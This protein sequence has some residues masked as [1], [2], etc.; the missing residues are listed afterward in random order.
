MISTF[1]QNYR[2]SLLKQYAASKN[3]LYEKLGY[4]SSIFFIL[5]LNLDR[6]S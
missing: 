4:L 3:Y 2:Y 5:L 6:I 1:S